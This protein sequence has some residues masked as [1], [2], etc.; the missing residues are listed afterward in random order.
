MTSART[1]QA[2]DVSVI[3]GLGER[4]CVALALRDAAPPALCD[5]DGEAERD[6]APPR[7]ADRDADAERDRDAA[8]ARL[9]D[10]DGDKTGM[11][12][13][14]DCDGE[15]DGDD[16]GVCEGGGCALPPAQSPACEHTEHVPN[17]DE[18]MLLPGV[19]DA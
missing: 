15:R 14:H 17:V 8:P 11:L 6:A 19:V 10:G 13:V 4:D 16:E 2:S 12:F 3:V 7:L 5:R 18:Q 9:A 1:W